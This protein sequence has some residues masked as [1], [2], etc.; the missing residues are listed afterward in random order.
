MFIDVNKPTTM[1]TNKIN[2]VD[3]FTQNANDNFKKHIKTQ[4]KA[5]L[6]IINKYIDWNELSKPIEKSIARAETGRKP[7]EILTI[8]KCFIL[9]S[10]YSLSDP[11]LEE[12]IADRRSFQIFLDITTGDSIPDETT[13]CKYRDMFSRYG[14]DKKL[15]KSFYNELKKKGLVLEQGTLVDAT[16]KQAYTRA[17]PHNNQN[18]RDKD[19]DFTK[20]GHKTIFGYKGHIGMD[21]K[22]KVI[23]SVEFTPVSIHDSDMFEK[24]LHN[25]E[26]IVM[27]DKGYANEKRKR[28]LRQ[29]GIYWAVLDKAYT[30]RPMTNKQKSRN[31]KISKIRNEVEKPFAFMKNVLNYTR[32]SYYNIKRNRF[33]FTLNT[34]IYNLRRMITLIPQ[35][36]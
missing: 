18:N 35:L 27:A 25:K 33:Q 15:F 36:T 24:V 17:I 21:I 1:R 7:F 30:H 5:A 9:Q 11:R 31:S 20:R 14:L 19:A 2:N 28:K 4:S 29:R 16:I 12:E 13:I 26:N 8:I 22:S 6:E 34:I 23:H 3:L 10:I 32:C